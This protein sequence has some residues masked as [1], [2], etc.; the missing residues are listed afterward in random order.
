MEDLRKL[1]GVV[2]GHHQLTIPDFME[3]VLALKKTLGELGMRHRNE[4]VQFRFVL[5]LAVPVPRRHDP[6]GAHVQA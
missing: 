2:A 3:D 6:A 5:I 4:G 1:L